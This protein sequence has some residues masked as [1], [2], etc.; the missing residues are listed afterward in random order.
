MQKRKRRTTE[1]D[2]ISRIDGLIEDLRGGKPKARQELVELV[3]QGSETT[4]DRLL[5]VMKHDGNG[6]YEEILQEGGVDMDEGVIQAAQLLLE[7]AR[8]GEDIAHMKNDMVN[9]L[10]DDTVKKTLAQALAYVYAREGECQE[11]EKLLF[12][13]DSEVRIGA[14]L[15]IAEMTGKG[16]EEGKE[17]V[18]SLAKMLEHNDYESAVAAA[19]I[20]GTAAG[21]WENAA[22]IIGSSLEVEKRQNEGCRAAW[23]AIRNNA[24]MDDHLRKIVDIALTKRNGYADWFATLALEEVPK[25]KLEQVC[26]LEELVIIQ[27]RIERRREAQPALESLTA[28]TE[29]MREMIRAKQN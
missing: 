11:I 14:L 13:Q 20:L 9:L 21:K 2:S 22:D 26:K 7:E 8:A 6:V 10:A 5:K 25:R 12:G 29:R 23:I 28:L 24:D 3:R 4:I 19:A 18:P 17:L 27:E 15:G 1:K 16:M